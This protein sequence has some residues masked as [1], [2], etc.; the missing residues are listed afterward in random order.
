MR[1]I[2]GASGEVVVVGA[3]LAGLAAA[4]HLAGRG[5]SVTVVER[6]AVPGGRAGRLDAGG[7]RIDTGPTVLTMP[8]IVEDAFAAV[9]E[10]RGAA[11]W[12]WSASTPP[13]ARCSPTAASSTCT[14]TPTRWPTRWPGS[15]A[16]PRPTATAGCGP[17]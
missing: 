17:G 15:P 4:L 12:T 7:Y 3:G 10:T 6:E 5:R 11:A 13:T 16:R 9:G 2:S 1:A 8:D 14:P